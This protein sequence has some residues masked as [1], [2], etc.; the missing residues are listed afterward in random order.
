MHFSHT[1]LKNFPEEIVELVKQKYNE[2]IGIK[3]VALI[4]N[5]V[6]NIQSD[7]LKIVNMNCAILNY[8]EFK[9]IINFLIS[10]PNMGR[11]I[12]HTDKSRG[13][14]LNIPVIVDNKNSSFI[15]GKYNDISKYGGYG[16][17]II[18]GKSALDFKYKEKDYEF[19]KLDYPILINTKIPHSWTNYANEY[20]VVASLSFNNIE[21][22]EEAFKLCEKWQ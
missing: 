5:T 19:I 16:K 11:A 7:R 21:K 12:I 6:K 22:Y 10:K 8:I 2:K 15:T 18:D 3:N 13:F 17:T 4:E 14:S 20:R 9:P 1:F